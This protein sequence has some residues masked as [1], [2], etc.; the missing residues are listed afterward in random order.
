MKTTRYKFEQVVQEVKEDSREW[1]R[2]ALREVLESDKDFTRKCDYIA[3]SILSIDAKVASLDEE[4]KELQQLKKSL[5]TAKDITLRIGA[6]VFGEYGVTKIEG[7]G[8]SSITVTES[9]TKETQKLEI[10]N[11]DELIR[12]GYYIKVID[13]DALMAAHEFRHRRELIHEF[14]HVTT[15]DTSTPPKLRINKRRAS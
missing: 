12:A 13:E 7:A 1:L 11:E 9:I 6:E 10:F 14:Y 5:K 3:F 8:V 2:D 15:I 4:I